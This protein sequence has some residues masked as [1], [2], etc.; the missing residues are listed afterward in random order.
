[1]A[2]STLI[3][4]GY[5]PR[6]VDA[7][8][9]RYLSI[10]GAVE[11]AG[12]KWCGKTW[13]SLAHAR[14][15]SYVDD[16]ID[17]A[18][19]DP[20]LVT[21]GEQP[22]VIDEWQLVPSIWNAV[23]RSIDRTRNLRGG[24]IL[25]GSSTP[26]LRRVDDPKPLHSGGGRIGRIRM[27]PMTLS[28]TGDSTGSISLAALFEGRFSRAVGPDDTLGLITLICR[29]GWP[30]ALELNALQ[31]QL[32]ARQYLNL[33]CTESAPQSGRNGD[34]SRLLA[35]SLA[36]NLGQAV[37]R[38]TLV[39][40]MS[41]PGVDGTDA[42]GALASVSTISDYLSFFRNSYLIDEIPGWVPASRS[43]KRMATKPKRY[44]ADPSLA[45]AQLG[46]DPQALMRDYQTL[47][48]VFENLCMRDLMVYASALPNIGTEPVRYYRD[49]TGLE[50]DAIIEL[51]DGRWAALE[52]K[53]SEDKVDDAVKSLQRLQRK[54]CGGG[55]ART[56]APEFMAVITGVSR[57]ARQVD[58][59]LYV[60]PIRCLTA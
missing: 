5:L 40:D 35:Y 27:H 1:M 54:L 47:G 59:N 19:T 33:F 16:D 20:Y 53:L 11:I 15:V 34:L 4:E 58:E 17:L 21:M 10:F 37:T 56:R 2:A 12:T 18:R 31:A 57:Y 45:V 39:A 3:P 41:E 36:R 13:T 46:M 23:R 29:G 55:G 42:D 52:I 50:V 28:E 22:H 32:V 26:F 51:A 49:D 24:W 48:L 9:E 44:F 7:Q 43:R 8:V 14:S 60:V 25:T 6:I 30:E 38:N